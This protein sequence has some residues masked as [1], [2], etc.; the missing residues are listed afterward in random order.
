MLEE[1][2]DFVGR[3]SYESSSNKK[4]NNGDDAKPSLDIFYRLLED[5]GIHTP[6][7]E[8]KSS[9]N[10]ISRHWIAA[11]YLYQV[12]CNIIP[13]YVRVKWD[14]GETESLKADVEKAGKVLQEALHWFERF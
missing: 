11:Q 8:S 10:A 9:T 7:Q 3:N 4:N 5:R 2:D 14:A 12:Q 6:L 1:E 13:W